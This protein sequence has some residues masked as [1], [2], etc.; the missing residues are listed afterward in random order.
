MRSQHCHKVLLLIMYVKALA[1]QLQLCLN[2]TAALRG[3]K[4]LAKPYFNISLFDLAK[5]HRRA[6]VTS[7][8]SRLRKPLR[9][10]AACPCC[11][12]R[13]LVT[14]WMTYWFANKQI[15][16]FF[17]S[18]RFKWEVPILGPLGLK[19][20]DFHE[21]AAAESLDWWGINYYSR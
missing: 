5:V 7:Q 16:N 21:P 6:L 19:V 20:I 17:T 12:L 2:T 9:L 13:S 4:P 8:Q 3:V 18:G 14:K 15:L 11:F 10:N 1:V